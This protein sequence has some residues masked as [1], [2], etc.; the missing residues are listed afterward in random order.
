METEPGEGLRERKKRQTKQ[1]LSDTATQ[2]FLA[3]G[4]D[5]V[6]VSEIA[7]ACGVS[8]ETGFNYF[9]TKEA[10]LM[11]RF[12]TAPQDLLAALTAPGRPP[13]EGMLRLLADE[14]SATTFWL[15]NQP[16]FLKAAGQVERFGTL[17]WSTPSLRA[18]QREQ[19]ERLTS[20]AAS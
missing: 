4:F 13:V 15:A 19:A 18:Y 20:E 3:Q 9:P 5:A 17:L 11:D 16:D 8:A 10:L 2:M 1:Q 7:E 6:R 14:L 12:Q